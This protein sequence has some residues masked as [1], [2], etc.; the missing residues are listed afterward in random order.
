M[1]DFWFGG[2]GGLRSVCGFGLVAT[3]VLVGAGL[4]VL[5]VDLIARFEWFG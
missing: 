5:G 1:L 4:L 2:F 3:F